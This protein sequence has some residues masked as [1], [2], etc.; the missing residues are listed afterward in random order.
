MA[1]QPPPTQ[2]DTKG[3]PTSQ[4]RRFEVTLKTLQMSRERQLQYYLTTKKI[5]SS[6]AA[7][8]YKQRRESWTSELECQAGVSDHYFINRVELG[9]HWIV[10]KL[11][12]MPPTNSNVPAA[13]KVS[14]LISTAPDHKHSCHMFCA[15]HHK[16]DPLSYRG[17]CAVK[18]A[19]DHETWFT[20][21]RELAL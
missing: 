13:S 6:R 16:L 1:N 10:M 9:S 5:P 12:A 15:K 21:I 8:K 18:V 19:H 17:R 4:T 2:P 11:A 20:T 14:S 3:L 7:K